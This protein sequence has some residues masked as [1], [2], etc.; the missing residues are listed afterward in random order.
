MR[1]HLKRRYRRTGV[2][3]VLLL[4]VFSLRG[5]ALEATAPSDTLVISYKVPTD[6]TD[7]NDLEKSAIFA[8]NEFIALT[9]PAAAQGPDAYPRETPDTNLEYGEVGPT[10]QVVWETFRHKVEIFPYFLGESPNPTGAPNGY[11]PTAPDYGY[12]SKP[13]YNYE[14]PIAAFPGLQG[15][16]TPFNNL[17]ESTEIALNVLFAGVV[18]PRMAHSG[19]ETDSG[20]KILFQAKANK[21]MYQ[22]AV[23]TALETGGQFNADLRKTYIDNGAANFFLSDPSTFLNPYTQL[24]ISDNSAVTLG[25]MELK[26]AF[27]RLG[28]QEDPSKF[29]TAPVRYYVEEEEDGVKKI[30][31]VD[32]NNSKQPET[33]A[34]IALHIIHKTANS[35]SFSYATFGHINNILDADGND[36]EEPDGT[37][38]APYLTQE[39]FDPALEITPSQNGMPQEVSLKG[40]GSVDTNS[41][42]LYYQNINDFV[43][44]KAD[45][46]PYKEPVNVNRRLFPIPPTITKVNAEAQAL[47]DGTVWANYRLVNIQARALDITRDATTIASEEPT[48]YL[49]NEVVETN[50]TLQHF[51]GGLTNS[52]VGGRGSGAAV[53]KVNM[54]QLEN[55]LKAQYNMGGCMGC[56]G[57]QGQKLGGDFSVIFSRSRLNQKPETIDEDEQELGESLRKSGKMV[58]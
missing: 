28:A 6:T 27:R 56:H 26:A 44:A 30:Y 10:G 18:K 12:D 52:G 39:P 16:T 24:P 31:Y 1:S 21:V 14:R 51:R 4:G 23:Q 15:E 38:K 34:L 48:Y 20:Q 54:Y 19:I 47:I 11:T 25:T 9:W 32:S 57:S 22:Y 7:P 58:Q 17:D 2:L 35:P 29:Y 41:N 5:L 37:T 49:A 45:G 40:S 8:W 53:D 3:T 46:S 33:W 55:N 42:R 13:E 43:I 36:V 50:A